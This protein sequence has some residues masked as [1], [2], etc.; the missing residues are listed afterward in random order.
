[1][2]ECDHDILDTDLSDI[3]LRSTFA[4]LKKW[5]KVI[6]IAVI[7]VCCYTIFLPVVFV[8]DTVFANSTV[9]S[10][11]LGLGLC[12]TATILGTFLGVILGLLPVKNL[13]YYLKLPLATLSGILLSNFALAVFVTLQI[14]VSA[15]G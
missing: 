8:E 2:D 12:L 10:F 6:Q 7:L 4:W 14:M 1:M 9:T 15:Y 11:T 3:K 5:R 13:P